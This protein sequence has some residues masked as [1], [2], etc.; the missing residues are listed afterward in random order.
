MS[1]LGRYST[2]NFGQHNVVYRDIS[3]YCTITNG[4][5]WKTTNPNCVKD[6]VTETPYA[7]YGPAGFPLPSVWPIET[8]WPIYW[9]RDYALGSNGY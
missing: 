8:L 1:S 5:Y 4:D 2:W 9:A 6:G 7:V 3:G